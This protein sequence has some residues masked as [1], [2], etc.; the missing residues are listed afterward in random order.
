MKRFSQYFRLLGCALLLSS[1]AIGQEVNLPKS[2]EAY[3]IDL[4]TV[5]RLANV[6]NLDVQIAR[7]RL[8]EARANETSATWQFFP[9][10]S[11]GVTYKKH[12]GRVQS[13][14]GDVFDASKGSL[15]PGITIAAEVD[16]G[17]AY[18]RRLAALQETKAA[19]EG[20]KAQQLESA[21]SAAQSYF[22]LLFTQAAADVARDAIRISSNY[23]AQ[24]EQAVEAGVAFRGDALRVA[25]QSE[26]YG[27]RLRQTLEERRVA[28]VR[29]AESLNLNPAID[30]VPEK[31]D[32]VP[33]EL[34]DSNVAL[35]A[36][37]ADALA[38]RPDLRQNEATLAAAR[39]NQKGAIYGPMVPTIGAQIFEGGLGGG[40]GGNLNNWGAQH[41]YVLGLSWRL[42]PGGMFDSGRTRAAEARVKTAALTLEKVQDQIAIQVVEATFRVN[43]LRDQIAVAKRVV[44]VSEDGFRLALERK[45]FSVGIVLETI[46]TEQDLTQAKFDYLK[47]IADFNKAQYALARAIGRFK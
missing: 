3:V 43:S 7:E 18:Y 4:P 28:A 30:L 6:Q 24:I 15:A 35:K 31:A 17:E 38:N 34:V 1:N 42:G 9:S 5:L 23:L 11:P 19:S 2:G 20:I 33:I 46:E 32:L 8:N 39:E 47:T 40:T 25:V 16:I 12:E 29:L 27:L 22:D 10:V 36:L 41:D 21:L 45:E 44:K 14:E 26:R 37:V 13:V